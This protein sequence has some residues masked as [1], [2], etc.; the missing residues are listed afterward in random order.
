MLI[1]G[2]NV[3]WLDGSFTI[4]GTHDNNISGVYTGYGTIED[5]NVSVDIVFFPQD[6]CGDFCNA[7]GQ[8]N[9]SFTTTTPDVY[10]LTL[11]GTIYHDLRIGS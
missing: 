4:T 10:E 6:G 5:G 7:Y 8:L 2:N 1:D 9:G 3:S 11:D